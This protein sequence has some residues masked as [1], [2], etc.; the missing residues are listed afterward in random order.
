MRISIDEDLREF[1]VDGHFHVKGAV[2]LHMLKPSPVPT[3]EFP[4]RADL[5]DHIVDHLWLFLR[6]CG[7]R[8]LKV[9]V[10]RM[11]ADADAMLRGERTVWSMRLGSPA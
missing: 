8:T 3:G 5:I 9:I 6:S 11:R 4:Q 10:A 7:G 1:G 2:R